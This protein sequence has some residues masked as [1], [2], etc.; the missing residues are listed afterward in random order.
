M[1]IKTYQVYFT[2][3]SVGRQGQALAARLSE[4][5]DDHGENLPVT[6]ISNDIF[7]VRDLTLTGR[8][9]RGTFAKLRDDAPHIIAAD[10]REHEITLEEGDR[11]LEKCHFLLRAPSNVLV[12]QYNKSAGGLSR[13]ADYLSRLL[14][15]MVTL[16]Y[17][18]QSDQLEQVLAGQVYEIDFAYDRPPAP[19]RGN[20][21][22]S[23]GMFNVMN[24][25]DAAHAKF[26]LRAPRFGSLDG[27]AKGI[28]RDMINLVGV[29]K[30]SVRLTDETQPID[31]FMQP[32]KGSL[33]VDLLGSYALPR[34]VF[35]GL[36]AAYNEH[37]G[38]IHNESQQ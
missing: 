19:Q 32:V 8:V 34:E 25:V 31:M 22:W 20:P 24:R 3:T 11:I 27:S 12:W 4:L 38:S 16:P 7:Q 1:A 6:T 5:R 17:I 13:F 26:L 33:Q 10:D 9:W 18:V 30:I 28:V 35:E 15:E 14:D 23:Q 2:R 36:E 21:R 29:K 37:R